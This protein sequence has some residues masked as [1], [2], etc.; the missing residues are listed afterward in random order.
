[1]YHLKGHIWIGEREFPLDFYHDG[2]KPSA[3]NHK[4]PHY[5]VEQNV[6]W[7]C[8]QC[9]YTNFAKRSKCHKCERPKS[10]VAKILVNKN[11]GKTQ[12]MSLMDNANTSLMIRGHVVQQVSES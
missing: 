2:A 7:Q 8:T 1:L 10:Q 11:A 3:N 5:M 6:D 12:L 4:L 9:N